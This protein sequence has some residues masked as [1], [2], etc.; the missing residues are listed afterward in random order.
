[1][2][3]VRDEDYQVASAKLTDSGFIRAA[4]DRTAPPEILGCLGSNSEMPVDMRGYRI[5]E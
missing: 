2:L 3:V 1:M 4:P 5:L